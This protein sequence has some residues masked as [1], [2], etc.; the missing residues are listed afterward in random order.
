MIDTVLDGVGEAEALRRHVAVDQVLEARLVNRDFT[1]LEHVDFALVVID[2]NDV[3]A[4]FREASARDETDI[5][6]TNDAEIHKGLLGA[7]KKSAD[8]KLGRRGGQGVVFGAGNWPVRGKAEE[9]A[10]PRGFACR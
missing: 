9:M 4:N 10:R 2:A 6:G 5:S 3:V 7:K 1:A 8:E